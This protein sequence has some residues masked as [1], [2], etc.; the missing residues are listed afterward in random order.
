MKKFHLG[1]FKTLET[2]KSLFLKDI[3][4]SKRIAQK[5]RKALFTFLNP[6][7][8]SQTHS[9]FV[10]KFLPSWFNAIGNCRYAFLG[11]TKTS[12]TKNEFF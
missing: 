9:P 6:T 4:L 8:I 5:L 7:G 2:K 12:N 1:F 11:K 3:R 10:E